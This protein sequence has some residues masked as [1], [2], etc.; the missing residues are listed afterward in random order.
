MTDTPKIFLAVYRTPYVED[1][2]KTKSIKAYTIN[3]ARAIAELN[4]PEHYKLHIIYEPHEIRKRDDDIGH[5][6]VGYCF[7]T[8]V[9]NTN[10]KAVFRIIKIT[11][12]LIK[13]VLINDSALYDAKKIMSVGKKSFKNMW[14]SRE[15]TPPEKITPNE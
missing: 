12:R 3:Q 4:S 11:K 1:G 10:T 13:Y 7:K 5:I 8:E 14:F 6:K 9:K 2:A 15:F